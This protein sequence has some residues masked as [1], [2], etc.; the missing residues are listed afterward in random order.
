M[1]KDTFKQPIKK[2]TDP[3]APFGPETVASSME[4]TGLIPTLPMSE[5]EA[6]AYSDL[7]NVHK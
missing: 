2:S 1:D 5:E 3:D 4:C 7:Y 6:E